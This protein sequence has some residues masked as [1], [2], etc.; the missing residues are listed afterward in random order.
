GSA[1]GQ[2][3]PWLPLL[4]LPLE[5]GRLSRSPAGQCPPRDTTSL[6]WFVSFLGPKKS[7][8]GL[9]QNG[10][11]FRRHVAGP[12]TGFV[13]P[14]GIGHAGADV[15]RPVIAVRRHGDVQIRTHLLRGKLVLNEQ[16]TRHV[17][18]ARLPYAKTSNINRVPRFAAN[19]PGELIRPARGQ[20]GTKRVSWPWSPSEKLPATKRH[21]HRHKR[22]TLRT[23][24]KGKRSRD[25]RGRVPRTGQQPAL[26]TAFHGVAAEQVD[27][28]RLDAP[29]ESLRAPRGR[30]LLGVPG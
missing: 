10:L 1:R 6:Q 3:S 22:E 30:C 8:H 28:G 19:H 2:A 23:A 15:A 16:F 11:H 26:P 9:Q 14:F 21:K 17:Q 7:L 4:P 18:D 29:D 25:H 13:A 27:S 20:R 5:Y 24:Q 12:W